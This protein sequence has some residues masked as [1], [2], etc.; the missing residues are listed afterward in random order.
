MSV[1]RV[2]EIIASSD[3]SFD[4]AVQQGVARAV[5]TLKNVRS[6]WVQDQKVHVENGKIASY[7]VNLKVTFVLED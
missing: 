5:K 4:D 6:A 1:A 2:T 7:R 3:V